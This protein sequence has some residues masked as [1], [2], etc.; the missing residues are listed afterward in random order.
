MSF[1][2]RVFSRNH[3]ASAPFAPIYQIEVV[4]GEA[5]LRKIRPVDP[6]FYEDNTNEIRMNS[7]LPLNQFKPSSDGSRMSQEQQ[8]EADMNFIAD[9]LKQAGYDLSKP[10]KGQDVVSSGS[11]TQQV[12]ASVSDNN[13]DNKEQ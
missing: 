11:D 9:E 10:F 5:V 7:G 12:S 8:V 13:T 1:R 6:Q 4:D 2:S 3:I